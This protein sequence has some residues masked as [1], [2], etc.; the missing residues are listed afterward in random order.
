M[1]MEQYIQGRNRDVSERAKVGLFPSTEVADRQAAESLLQCCNR[2]GKCPALDEAGQD[3]LGA[4][5]KSE[6]INGFLRSLGGLS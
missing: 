4:A 3:V 5:E 6:M 2:G 1:T